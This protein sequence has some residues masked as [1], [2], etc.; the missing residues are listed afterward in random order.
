MLQEGTGHIVVDNAIYNSALGTNGL[1]CFSFDLPATSYTQIDRNAC[2]QNGKG[3]WALGQGSLATWTAKMGFDAHSMLANP[4][5]I[6]MA[7]PFN[8]AV[9]GTSPL[10]NAGDAV[11]S[12]PTDITGKARTSSPDIGA[13]EL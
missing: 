4:A 7:S 8:L 2:F 1:A 9:G 3:E 11:N 10:V 6:S 13:Y 5:F 12:A